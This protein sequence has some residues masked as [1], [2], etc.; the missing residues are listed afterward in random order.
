MSPLAVQKIAVIGSGIAG[1]SAAWRLSQ[2]HDVTLYEA[3]PRL[4]GHANTVSTR[5]GGT[6]VDVDTGF[7]VFNPPNYPNF[8]PML[9][10]LGVASAPSDMS[11][12]ASLEERKLYMQR[13]ALTSVR[14]ATRAATCGSG[15]TSARTSRHIRRI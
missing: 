14:H 1:L 10:H 7:I 5:I 2:T 9:A 8:T 13:L 3:A 6:D 11:F 15:V 4:G 12:S